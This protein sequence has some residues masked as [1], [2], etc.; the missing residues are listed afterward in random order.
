MGIYFVNDLIIFIFILPYFIPFYFRT[1][2]N[3]IQIKKVLS[4][5][6]KEDNIF[7]YLSK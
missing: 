4:Y 6:E 3:L 7:K 1:I 5:K 2:I